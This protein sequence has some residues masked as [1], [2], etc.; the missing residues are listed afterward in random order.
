MQLR[1]K[2]LLSVFNNRQALEK[3]KQKQKTNTNGMTSSKMLCT[4]FVI[5]KFK[6]YYDF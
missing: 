3:K 4:D 6:I 2:S 5:L 1:V